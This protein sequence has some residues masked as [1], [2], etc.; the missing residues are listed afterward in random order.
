MTSRTIKPLALDVKELLESSNGPLAV[1]PPPLRGLVVAYAPDWY[2]SLVEAWIKRWEKFPL[3]HETAIDMAHI[4]HCG[5]ASRYLYTQPSMIRFNVRALALWVAAE[6]AICPDLF[7]PVMFGPEPA[8]GRMERIDPPVNSEWGRALQIF[9][10]ET[11]QQLLFH[12]FET[13]IVYYTKQA[14]E[15]AAKQLPKTNKKG[16]ALHLCGLWFVSA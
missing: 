8:S 10:N 11:R 12:T 13:C 9:S 1:F 3:L 14:P 5:P 7:K 16:E 6:R 15:K 2:T 4:F